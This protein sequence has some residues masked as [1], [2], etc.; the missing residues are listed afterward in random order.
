MGE[1]SQPP[2]LLNGNGRSTACTELGEEARIYG[3]SVCA[4]ILLQTGQRNVL[5][6]NPAMQSIYKSQYFAS[7]EFKVEALTDVWKTEPLPHWL[8]LDSRLN[9]MPFSISASSSIRQA[10]WQGMGMWEFYT[11]DNLSFTD[12]TPGE[13]ILWSLFLVTAVWLSCCAN[14]RM[15]LVWLNSFS[16]LMTCPLASF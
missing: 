5:D 13:N 1:K 15:P 12:S 6:F 9:F 16:L 11:S 4:Q 2:L 7:R 14:I 8:P 10:V 3:S